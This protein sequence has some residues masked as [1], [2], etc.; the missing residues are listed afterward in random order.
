MSE[1]KTIS[2]SNTITSST[3]KKPGSFSSLRIPNFR[4]LFAGSFLGSA[5]QWIQQVVLSWL[6]YDITGSGTILGSIILVWS[7][8]ALSM[9]VVAGMLVDYYNRRSLMLIE[10]IC[11]FTSNLA[12]GLMLFFGHTHIAYLFIF[13][14]IVGVAQTLDVTVRQVLVFDVVPRAQTPSAMALTQTGWSLMRV[15]GPTIGGFLL[16]WFTAGGTFLLQAGIYILI[17][18]TIIMIKL[19]PRQKDLVRS[20]PIQ[21]IKDGVGFMV[22]KPLV[23]TFTIIGILL[24]FFIIPMF[25]TLPPIYAA[26]LFGD[27]SGK[28]L[29]YLLAA[30]GAGGI[31]GG[32]VATY[33]RRLE[34]W[35]LIGLGG[36]FMLSTMLIA[37]AFTSNLPLALAILVLVGFFEIISLT[38]IQTLIQLSI[39][40]Q[41]RGRVTAA[42]NLIW[43]VLSFGSIVIGAGSD[44]LG[45]KMITI[46]AAGLTAAAIVVIFLVSSTTRNFRLS[47]SIESS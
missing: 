29:G 13:S 11:I 45:P 15:L 16:I 27:D 36:L 20:S 17:F 31:I 42:V 8:G 5:I 44:L 18:I 34:R 9:L 46:I 4:L 40:D 23:R 33:L 21:N 6:V 38:V 41:L 25:N 3:E 47:K 22:K 10:T 14:F 19:P 39:P 2:N 26:Q 30:V 12:L 35:G 1:D 28:T 43:M 7:A 24:S 37:F 32:I